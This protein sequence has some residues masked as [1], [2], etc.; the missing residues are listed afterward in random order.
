MPKANNNSIPPHKPLVSVICR[1]TGRA[2]LGEALASVNRQKHKLIEVV[3]VDAKGKGISNYENLCPDR[4]VT[5]VSTGAKLK[6]SRA[7]NLG[8]QN[9]KGT[10]LMFLDEDDW[11]AEDHIAN[12][13]EILESNK[14]IIAA[15]STTRKAARDGKLLDEYFSQDFDAV[16][17]KRDNF[18]PIHAM[19]FSA[20]LVSKG[21]QFDEK[22]D[23]YEDWDFWLQL[24]AHGKFQH[25][26]KCT[27]F[28]RQGGD[29]DTAVSENAVRYDSQHAIGK[30]RAQIFSKWIKHWSGE[31]FNHLLGSMDAT[32]ELRE[33]SR[34][35]QQLH[36]ELRKYSERLSHQIDEN[37]RLQAVA[38]NTELRSTELE[39]QLRHSRHHVSDLEKEIERIHNT[40]SW[41][42]TGPFRRIHRF[43]TVHLIKP[44]AG[45]FSRSDDSN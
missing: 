2:E 17:L 41:R 6:R 29:S 30:A 28:Y 44:V 43:V 27:A 7:A 32:D 13:V 5:L 3:L 36:N 24:S 21:C 23:I 39:G 22:L 12:L 15:Y 19:L 10:F 42:I 18:I 45:A 25:L 38:D 4:P 11:I 16:L 1:T 14:D 35:K 33:L 34:A 8:L 26:D 40:L 31:D 20:N 9:S 37:T